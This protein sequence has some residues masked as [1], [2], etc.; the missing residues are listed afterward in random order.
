ML[1]A[2]SKH[3][4]ALLFG[5]TG[6]RE[7]RL[8][9]F[10]PVPLRTLSK[11]CRGEPPLPWRVPRRSVRPRWAVR[12]HPG[13]G[14]CWRRWCWSRGR[15]LRGPPWVSWT[16]RSCDRSPRSWTKTRPYNCHERRIE[17]DVII[18][19]GNGSINVYTLDT[20]LL[21]LQALFNALM[22]LINLD[23]L[24]S[25]IIPSHEYWFSNLCNFLKSCFKRIIIPLLSVWKFHF[26]IQ[27]LP[28]LFANA[29]FISLIA[30][31]VY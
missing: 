12:P 7:T 25:I 31:S 23:N 30:F 28:E 21:I 6:L 16:S 11:S 8:S 3:L 18:H 24:Q 5:E 9:F 1:R 26:S 17:K 15:K 10:R 2:I 13:S 14:W 27:V 20:I 22:A 4:P 19:F 29:Y